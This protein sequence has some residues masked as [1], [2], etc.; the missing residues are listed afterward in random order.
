M[1]TF[2][3]FV[4]L[5]AGCSRSV[6]NMPESERQENWIGRGYKGSCAWASMI[7]LLRAEGYDAAAEL[8]RH[9]PGGPAWDE[10]LSAVLEP[11]GVVLA[12]ASN[13]DESFLELACSIGPGCEVAVDDDKRT[14]H[15]VDLIGLD[16]DW[17]MICDPNDPKHLFRVPRQAFLAEWHRCGGE[18]IRLLQWWEH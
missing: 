6:E 12:V 9:G 1:K 16:D 10:K 14:S 18:A 15:A 3:V 17:A 13:G 11:M 5:F 4:L 8:L 7:T 2:L